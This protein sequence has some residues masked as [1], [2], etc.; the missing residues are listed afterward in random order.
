MKFSLDRLKFIHEAELI[1]DEHLYRQPILDLILAALL[2]PSFLGPE[3]DRPR[4]SNEDVVKLAVNCL[5]ENIIMRIIELYDSDFNTSGTAL[6]NL[7]QRGVGNRI[8][9]AMLYAK[10]KTINSVLSSEDQA[11]AA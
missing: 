2:Q 6:L 9:E 1:E 8:I 7:G 3:H 11:A 4:L 5:P 10:F